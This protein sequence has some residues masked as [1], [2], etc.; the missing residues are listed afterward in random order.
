MRD[1]RNN[2]FRAASKEM[3][4]SDYLRWTSPVPR[5]NG[6]TAIDPVDE[7]IMRAHPEI[8][9]SRER[10]VFW[11]V[12]AGFKNKEMAG[13]L[14]IS[15]R[16]V[17]AHRSKCAIKIPGLRDAACFGILAI[18]VLAYHRGV[19]RRDAPSIRTRKTV[20]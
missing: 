4:K 9:T 2:R 12:A 17:E 5:R 14:E 7:L 6:K 16:T 10:V 1:S 19:L 13:F 18:E 3:T 15:Q 11:L 20:R 8:L